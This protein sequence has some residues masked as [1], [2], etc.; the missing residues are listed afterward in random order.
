MGVNEAVN[1]CSFA[2][3][4]G[5]Y[6]EIA[7]EF[8]L[9]GFSKWLIKRAATA[10]VTALTVLRRSARQALKAQRKIVAGMVVHHKN[11]LRGHPG[12]SIT[13]FPTGGLP[14]WVANHAWNLEALPISVHMHRHK[15]MR[16]LE[17]LL[18]LNTNR[19]T[20]PTRLM[21][22][23]MRDADNQIACR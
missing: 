3:Q 7:V 21:N 10:S 2:Y 19:F 4:A 9:A 8:A 23:L 1:K 11:P 14:K 22:N 17:N 18:R 6:T 15:E 20:T 13:L 12:G 16:F 5:E